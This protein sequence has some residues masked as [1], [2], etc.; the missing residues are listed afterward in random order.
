[1]ENKVIA[2]VD[3]R[4]VTESHLVSLVQSLGQNAARFA[5]EGGRKQLVEELI[6][7]ELFYSDAI[8]NG[9]DKDAEFLAAAENMYNTLLKQYAL[10]KLLGTVTVSDEEAESYFNDHKDTFKS[11]P[12]ARASH[13][14][15]DS[16]EQAEAILE[17]ING[18]LS[19][20]EAASKY[21]SCPSRERGGDLG[22]FGKG[23]MV[24]EFE[25]AV[26][27][28]KAGEVSAPIQTQFGY[29]IIKVASVNEGEDAKFEDVKDRVK[30][31][32]MSMKHNAVYT[33]KQAELKAKYT[34]E[35]K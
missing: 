20:E 23:Q 29:H 5:G 19:F 32:V 3:G 8:A 15:V 6:T 12:S 26:F 24:P 9:L 25:N 21:S 34:V 33:A 18:G 4:E 17:E 28:M 22:E 7:Q 30:Q 1:M 27:N 13:I 35:V 31:L 10:S 11:G 14:L 16:K 2:V